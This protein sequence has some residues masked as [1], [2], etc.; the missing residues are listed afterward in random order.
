MSTTPQTPDRRTV[1]RR[2]ALALVERAEQRAARLGGQPHEYVTKAEFEAL[3]AAVRPQ[4][5]SDGR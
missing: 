4:G 5:A 3:R 1:I 2:R